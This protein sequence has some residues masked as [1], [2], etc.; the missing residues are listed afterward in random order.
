MDN[1]FAPRKNTLQQCSFVYAPLMKRYL[2]EKLLGRHVFGENVHLVTPLDQVP[3]EGGS[4]ESCAANQQNDFS[5]H[6]FRPLV[7]R[8][9]FA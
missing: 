3:R 9:A 5:I 8:Y 6:S 1:G 2:G 4:D 7:D